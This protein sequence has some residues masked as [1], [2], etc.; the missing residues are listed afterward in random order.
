MEEQAIIEYVKEKSKYFN[1][2][3]ICEFAGVN[4]STFRG[5][6]NA[7]RSLSFE[8]INAIYVAM[9]EVVK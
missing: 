4:Y 1:M 7:D 6:K 9:H 2:K 5:W 3:A 8:K